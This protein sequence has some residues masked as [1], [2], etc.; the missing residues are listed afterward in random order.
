MEEGSITIFNQ[1]FYCPNVLKNFVGEPFCLSIVS[2]IEKNTYL[3]VEYH[4]FLWKRS[5][6]T[7]PR[8]TV[9]EHILVSQTLWYRNII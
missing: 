7:I 2:D 1:K 6:L 3:R 5:C 8:N 4:D 9:G